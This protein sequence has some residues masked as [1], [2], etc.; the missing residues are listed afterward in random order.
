MTDNLSLGKK[1]TL[2]LASTYLFV[3]AGLILFNQYN[4]S[5]MSRAVMQ[6]EAELIAETIIVA[7]ANKTNIGNLKRISNAIGANDVVDNVIVAKAKTG[8]ILASNKNALI[9]QSFSTNHLPFSHLINQ[10]NLNQ[11]PS[12][13]FDGHQLIYM[14]SFEAVSENN[15]QLETLIVLLVINPKQI[16]QFVALSNQSAF[17]VSLLGLAITLAITIFIVQ[18]QAIKP[19]YLLLKSINDG[20]KSN[21]PKQLKG[22]ASGEIGAL[23]SAYNSLL[24]SL[25]SKQDELAEQTKLSNKAVQAKSDFLSVMSHE[26]RT[27]LNGVLGTATL[28]QKT[29]LSDEQKEYTDVITNSGNQLLAT[30]NDILDISKIEAGKLHINPVTSDINQL[31]K[32]V[33]E[34]FQAP[35]AEKAISLVTHYLNEPVFINIDDIRV[36]Q[37]LINLV[38]NAIKFT[39]QGS[40]SISIELQPSETTKRILILSVVDTGIGLTDEQTA[41]LFKKFVQADASTTRKYGGTGLGLSICQALIDMMQGEIKVSSQ[42]DKGSRFVVKLPCEVATEQCINKNNH[43]TQ[44]TNQELTILLVDDVILNQKIASAMLKSHRITTANNGLEAVNIA[45][46]EQFDLILMDCLM[47]EMDGFTATTLIRSE[48]I[49]TPI[50]ALTASNQTETKEKC[51]SAGMNDFVSKPIVENELLHVINKWGNA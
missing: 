42:V 6:H 21:H 32:T 5:K 11:S 33:V 38:S 46:S 35:C 14:E 43:N 39:E 9:G 34:M 16:E 12:H 37:I 49:T 36:K 15:R 29:S 10:L 23:F 30:I 13:Y 8:L 22:K 1:I 25:L 17:F 47:P 24:K 18:N 19:I 3:L 2:I 51:E 26:I 31:V 20:I 41:N 40:V 7:T 44:T 50:I 48:G 28:L 27:P 45:K 4:T